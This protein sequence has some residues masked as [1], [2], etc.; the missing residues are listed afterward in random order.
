MQFAHKLPEIPT[1]I[2]SVIS[3]RARELGALNVGQGFPD[4]PIDPALAQCVSQAMAAGHNQY[5]PMEGSLGLREAISRKLRETQGIA[6]DPVSEITVTC[7]GTEA[8]HSAIQAI[9]RAGDEVICFDPAYDAYEPAVQLTGGRCIR[10][11]SAPPAFRPDWDRFGDALS[12]R[13][14]L[15]I[16]NNPHN[17]ACIVWTASDLETLAELIRERPILV[18][19][20][21]VYEHLVF[22]DARHHSVLAHPE[23]ASRSLAVF[24]F[25][26]TF[27]ITGWRVGYCVAPR[28][29]TDELRKVHQ[30]NTFSIAAPLQ[31]GI[32]TYLAER[33]DAWRGLAEFFRRKRDLVVDGLRGTGYALPPAQGTYFQLLDCSAVT[34]LDDV[35]FAEHLLTEAGVALIPLS[36]F[37]APASGVAPRITWLRLCVA[38]RDETLQLA[39]ERLRAFAERPAFPK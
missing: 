23:L 20:D 24:S 3:R 5:A 4:Y 16:T 28:E 2:F 7:G 15:I 14:R 19:A 25:G 31:Q 22:G 11:P 29:W 1:T 26:K 21:E 35:A 37:Y 38:K 8:L 13:T 6:P 12:D 30:F 33:P 34:P 17:P 10:I 32:A 36:P 18:L 27:H 39:V 9:V